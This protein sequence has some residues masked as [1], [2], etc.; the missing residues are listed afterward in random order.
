MTKGK[1]IPQ[2]VRAI[3]A[4]KA[5]RN[6]Q[7]HSPSG[8]GHVRQPDVAGDAR[9]VR[10]QWNHELRGPDAP[11]E[12]EINTVVGS[13]HPSEVKV[14]PLAGAAV[15]RRGQQKTYRDSAFHLSSGV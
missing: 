5:V 10:I 1:V 4:T 6:I 14:H 7:R 3:E 11:P 8:A 2:R 9:D 12:S 15:N 13:D